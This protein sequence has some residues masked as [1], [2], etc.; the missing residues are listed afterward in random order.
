MAATVGTIRLED[1]NGELVATAHCSA[2]KIMRPIDVRWAGHVYHQ[3]R[4]D[5]DGVWVYRAFWQA[6]AGTV[7]DDATITIVEPEPAA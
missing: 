7:E 3:N 4:Q 5:P 2:P 6:A 1:G